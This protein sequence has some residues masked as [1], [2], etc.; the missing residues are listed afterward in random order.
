M[1]AALREEL[2][3]VAVDYNFFNGWTNIC[4]VW[5]PALMANYAATLGYSE[6]IVGLYLERVRTIGAGIGDPVDKAIYDSLRRIGDLCSSQEH[7]S[8][9]ELAGFGKGVDDIADLGN[10]IEHLKRSKVAKQVSKPYHVALLACHDTFNYYVGERSYD[11]NIHGD[12]LVRAFEFLSESTDFEVSVIS[13]RLLNESPCSL[14]KYAAVICPH[15]PVVADSVLSILNNYITNQNGILVQ[16]VRFGLLDPDGLPRG[17]WCSSLFGIGSIEWGNG[18]FFKNLNTRESPPIMPL[19]F[20]NEMPF[21]HALL[22]AQKG[23]K[24]VLPQILE[25]GTILKNKGLFV[26][27]DNVISMG[28]LPY[29]LYGDQRS[30]WCNFLQQRL[31]AR[32]KE[33]SLAFT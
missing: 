20:S 13:D 17:N 12:A 22:T 32:L 24:V 1:I 26:E 29:L 23:F 25:D 7:I 15:Q 21:T 14:K 18:A 30:I 5:K 10:V 4:D 11:R 27:S 8:G 31:L 19:A 33:R 3:L 28:M 6:V 2:D 16:D 9:Y